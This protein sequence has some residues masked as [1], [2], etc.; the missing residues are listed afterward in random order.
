MKRFKKASVVLCT[1]FMALAMVGCGKSKKDSATPTDATPADASSEDAVVSLNEEDYDW[2]TTEEPDTEG[3][4]FPTEAGDVVLAFDFD[5][6]DLHKFTT[7]SNG[8]SFHLKAKDDMMVAEITRTGSVEHGCQAYW[9]GFAMLQGCEYTYTFDISCDIERSIEWRVQVNGGDFHAYAS[10]HV[11]IGPE[12]QTITADFT[13][14]EL[15]DPAPRLVFNMGRVDDMGDVPEHNIYIDNISLVVKDGSNAI[16]VEPLPTPKRVRVNQ[17][18]YEPDEKKYVLTASADDEVF[19]VVNVDTNETVFVGAYGEVD[20]NL[21][22]G[23]KA[24]L[25]EFTSVTEPGTYKIISAPSGESYEFKIGE[26]VYSDV[27]K[28][29]VLM[30]YRQRCGCDLDESIAGEFAHE[31]C[32]TTAAL[33]YDDPSA[34]AKD[35]SGGWH[36]AGDYGRYVVPAAKTIEDLFITYEDFGATADDIGIPE[37]GNGV[38]DLLDE[39]RYELEWMLKMQADDGGVYH[40]VTALV[41]PETVNAVDETAQLYLA[42]VSYA[43]TGDFV[44]VMAKASVLYRQ[45]DEEFADRCLEAALKSYDYISSHDTSFYINPKEIVTG[46]YGDRRVSDEYLWA[47]TELYF[48]TGDS[49]YEKE[50]QTT[51]ETCIVEGLGWATMGTYPLYELAKAEGIPQTIKDLATEKF[52]KEVNRVI[53]D[54]NHGVLAVDMSGSF[55]WGSNMRVANC[56]MLLLMANNISPSDEYYTMASRQKDYIFG[57]NGPAYCYVTGYGTVSPEHSHHRPSQVLGKTM[58]GMLIGGPDN[59]LEDPYALAVLPGV[60]P[61]KSYVDNE[62]SY[63]CNEVTIY[64]NSPLIYLMTGLGCY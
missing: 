59:A 2:S 25:G 50:I 7:Y 4:G 42:P 44:A 5:D 16:E 53:S 38:P 37:S 46:E 40:K 32:H 19:K 45:Y 56:G 62:Q 39:A 57:L 22:L 60:A 8:G 23:E 36:D 29:V 9:D 20:D 1:A 3:K 58:P 21:A 28:D 55:Q 14:E 35:V 6:D 11:K 17:I 54:C 52:Y 13:M 48:A 30:L 61:A 12:K 49:K 41:F 24:R 18:G 64:W 33:V 15:S 63:S 31:A 51:L 43:A 47:N 34:P 10:D 26:G 27:Y